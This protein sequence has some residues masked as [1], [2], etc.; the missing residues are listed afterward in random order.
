VS[1][2]TAVSIDTLASAYCES[3]RRFVAAS[4]IAAL[5]LRLA[6]APD[7]FEPVFARLRS[8]PSGTLESERAFF[9]LVVYQVH[10]RWS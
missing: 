1:A 2:V 4:F 3:P 8:D 6:F 7:G 9:G 5:A 10:R